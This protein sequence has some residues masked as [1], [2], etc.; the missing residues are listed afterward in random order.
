MEICQ[1]FLSPDYSVQAPQL[2]EN[3]GVQ[4][5]CL[6]KIINYISINA[7][8][9]LFLFAKIEFNLPGYK[10]MRTPN[11]IEKPIPGRGDNEATKEILLAVDKEKLEFDAMNDIL[12]TL[13]EEFKKE[14]KPDTSFLDWL[15]SKDK[16]YFQRLKYE[17][18]GP[19]KPKVKEDIPIK[20]IDL[21]SQLNKLGETFLKMNKAEREVV[22]DL[23]RRS[24]LLD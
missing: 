16:D 5:N 12:D 8:R 11:N 15:K 23:L 6:T 4:K 10:I 7:W 17:A 24:G 20:Q 21:D 1:S 13:M 2:Y 14:A 19:V 9:K 18:G 22:K 3:V